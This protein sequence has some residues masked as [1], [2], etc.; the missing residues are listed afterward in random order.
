MKTSKRLLSILL[1]LTML[2]SMFTV[3]ASAEAADETAEKKTQKVSVI[4]EGDGSVKV[5]NNTYTSNFDFNAEAGTK[6][7]VIGFQLQRPMVLLHSRK[8]ILMPSQP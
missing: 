4:I 7:V 5:G 2:L 1:M 8:A 3:M 6:L